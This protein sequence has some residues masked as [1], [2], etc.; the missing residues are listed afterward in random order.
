MY[1]DVSCLELYP[2]CTAHT[3]SATCNNTSYSSHYTTTAL[4]G[5]VKSS[6]LVAE[7][8]RTIC[9]ESKLKIF[10]SE[11]GDCLCVA[12]PSDNTAGW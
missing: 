6:I 5:E 4:L 2:C 1:T 12:L 9:E 3:T 7:N 11:S 8:K 10:A